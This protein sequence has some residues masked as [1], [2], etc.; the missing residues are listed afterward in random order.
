LFAA[1]RSGRTLVAVTTNMPTDKKRIVKELSECAKDEVGDAD[2]QGARCAGG[3]GQA[4]GRREGRKWAGSQP[5]SGRLAG[6]LAGR[7]RAW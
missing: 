1:T 3:R 2:W 5:G 6:W 4:A 7:L